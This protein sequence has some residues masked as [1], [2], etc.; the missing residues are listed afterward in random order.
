MIRALIFDFDGLIVDTETPALESWRRIY[1]EYGFELGL[2]EWSPALGTRHGFDALEHLVGLVA[3]LQ[4]WSKPLLNLPSAYRGLFVDLPGAPLLFTT[5]TPVGAVEH[6]LAQPC[7]GRIFNEM[8]YGS[9]MAWALYPAA[10]HFIDPRVELFP[11]A[12]WQEYRAVS[13]GRD[14]A[15]FFDRHAIA[16][17]VI[18]KELQP[19]LARAMPALAGWQ[20]TFGDG[21]T[22]VWRR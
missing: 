4:P 8:G 17:A 2:E 9:Y 18:D 11:L 7:Q 3:A 16:C 15:G 14:V 19:E 13:E 5:E 22:E 10:Q 6:L 21:R 12:L 20:R 1:A